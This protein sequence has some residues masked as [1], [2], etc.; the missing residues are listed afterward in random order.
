[1]EDK[2]RL[3]G[4]LRSLAEGCRETKLRM[5]RV[6]VTEITDL[7]SISVEL[8]WVWIEGAKI[9]LVRDTI[10]ILI[11]W[12]AE[13]GHERDVDT[14]RVIDHWLE[15]SLLIEGALVLQLAISR[16]PKAAKLFTIHIFA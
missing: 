5:V 2:V 8:H 11:C 1:M 13:L 7:I 3:K 14:C 9:N 4:E 12:R 10:P 16:P 15:V 6:S